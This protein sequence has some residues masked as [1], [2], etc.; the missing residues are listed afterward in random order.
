MHARA[1]AG[2]LTRFV[3]TCSA[4][5][6]TPSLRVCLSQSKSLKVVRSEADF[7][8]LHK[9][10][11]N[12]FTTVTIAAVPNAKAS[13]G[14]FPPKD[15]AEDRRQALEWWLTEVVRH[16]LLRCADA[17]RHFLSCDDNKKVAECVPPK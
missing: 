14:F 17:T 11:S 6:L 15:I 2:T 7:V 13:T 3:V 10:L 9:A 5:E 8:W 12:K 1:C 4:H 16:G